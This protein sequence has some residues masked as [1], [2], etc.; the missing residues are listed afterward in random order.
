[1]IQVTNHGPLITA[2]DYWQS[3]YAEAGKMLVSPN[4]GTIRCLLPP[5]Q[6][7]VVGDLRS[8]EYAIVSR[9]PWQGRD[10]IEIL[11]EDHTD[12]PHAWHLTSESCLMLPGDPGDD[13]WTITCWVERRG[14]PHKAIERPCHW[15]RVESLPSL[16]KSRKRQTN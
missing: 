2:T 12:S 14:R 7:P 3:E 4:A 16:P 8:T 13:H 6:Y 9:G 15:R 11:W 5:N 1:M 10:A